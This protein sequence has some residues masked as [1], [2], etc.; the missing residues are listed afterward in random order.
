MT[1]EKEKQANIDIDY[2]IKKLQEAT[3]EQVRK[4]VI[5]AMNICKG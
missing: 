1:L 5:C 4:M 3:P 2:V